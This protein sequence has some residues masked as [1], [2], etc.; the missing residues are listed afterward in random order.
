MIDPKTLGKNLLK[1]GATAITILAGPI[2][3]HYLTK[4]V[5]DGFFATA[6]SSISSSSYP[7][8]SVALAMVLAL[9]GGW[10]AKSRHGRKQ[11]QLIQCEGDEI[12]ARLHDMATLRQTEAEE[13]RR[14]QKRAA[15]FE[16][17]LHSARGSL[18]KAEERVA[19]MVEEI[20]TKQN[21]NDL[22]ERRLNETFSL[23]KQLEDQ[24]EIQRFSIAQIQSE[25]E[26]KESALRQK[27]HAAEGKISQL[28]EVIGTLR[29][30][31]ADS[32]SAYNNVTAKLEQTEA[33][34]AEQQAQLLAL[35]NSLQSQKEAAQLTGWHNSV[36]SALAL[37][38]SRGDYGMVEVIAKYSGTNVIKCLSLLN[39]LIKFDMIK[40][41]ATTSGMEY[42]L[43]AEGRKLAA[44]IA[45]R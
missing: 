13:A 26:D 25:F 14:L 5:T 45:N 27:Q 36:V 41:V 19:K 42:A 38:E 17:Q 22:C 9:A 35:Q 33:L 23:K 30:A 18:A 12:R 39:D 3:D 11:F 6:W 8:W 10:I 24:L 32:K 43:S 1:L 20:A 2:A 29:A 4:D 15:E 16:L 34:C 40:P 21:A 28:T 7:N 37:V 31:E 44:T